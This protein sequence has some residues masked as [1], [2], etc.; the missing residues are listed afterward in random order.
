M[1]VD[2]KCYQWCFANLILS[3]VT[4]NDKE[5][6][7]LVLHTVFN[8]RMNTRINDLFNHDLEVYVNQKKK[9]KKRLSYHFKISDSPLGSGLANQKTQSCISDLLQ[10]GQDDTFFYYYYYIG[11]S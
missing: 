10:C 4:N 7:M 3:F 2:K 6:T 9:K 8:E 1:V 11:T 5:G